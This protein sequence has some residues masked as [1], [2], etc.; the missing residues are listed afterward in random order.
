MAFPH[1]G[2]LF[3]SHALA[4]LQAFRFSKGRA[5]S[6]YASGQCLT[7][8]GFGLIRV[9]C[10]Y[11]NTNTADKMHSNQKRPVMFLFQLALTLEK[12]RGGGIVNQEQSGLTWLIPAQTIL[13]AAS[14]RARAVLVC[15]MSSC[16][17]SALCIRMCSILVFPKQGLLLLTAINHFIASLLLLWT[18][19]M[20]F[21]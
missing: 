16:A 9:S 18:Q 2:L 1:S 3:P 7:Q 11:H 13:W 6:Y 20:C 14:A 10:D 21:H 17:W 5:V 12:S 19:Q 8:E 15:A 4:Y